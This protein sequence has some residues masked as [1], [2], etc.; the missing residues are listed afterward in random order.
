M[1][2]GTFRG[3]G[4]FNK[5]IIV[6]SR[7]TVANLVT[8]SQEYYNGIMVFAN[9]VKQRDRSGKRVLVWKTPGLSPSSGGRFGDFGGR[10]FFSPGSIADPFDYNNNSEDGP[11][12]G[13]KRRNSEFEDRM[14]FDSAAG[15]FRHLDFPRHPG[16]RGS[17]RRSLVIFIGEENKRKNKMSDDILSSSGR[18][19]ITTNG[20][21]FKSDDNV[22]GG[23]VQKIGAM[24]GKRGYGNPVMVGQGLPLD[25]LKNYN[26]KRMRPGGRNRGSEEGY[27]SN[28]VAHHID[29]RAGKVMLVNPKIMEDPI[30]SMDYYLNGRV[31]GPYNMS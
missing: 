3:N 28:E 14:Y 31:R 23:N 15:C 17:S 24:M 5:T 13:N 16:V 2:S 1:N 22:D 27:F 26:N 11:Y 25:S 30:R 20:R 8:T 9:V 29:P 4:D 21:K 7:P 10:R 12:G 18:G 6:Q 19:R